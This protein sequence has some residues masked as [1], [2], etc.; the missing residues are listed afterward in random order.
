M[1]G[2]K[3]NF[4][5]DSS[6]INKG[7]NNVKKGVN[8]IKGS[9]HGAEGAMDAM[10]DAADGA[11]RALDSM[12]GACGAAS[13]GVSGLAGDLVYLVKNPIAAA[14]AALAA[15]AA[16]ASS[17]Y[18]NFTQNSDEFTAQLELQM[19]LLD[20]KNANMEKALTRQSKYFDKLKQ[21][22]KLQSLT[23]NQRKSAMS[24]IS[25]LTKSYGDLGISIDATTGKL[26]GLNQA[27][28]QFIKLQAE[29]RIKSLKGKLNLNENQII[30]AMVS[31]IPGEMNGNDVIDYIAGMGHRGNTAVWNDTDKVRKQGLKYVLPYTGN[32]LI[33][34]K[35]QIEQMNALVTQ[36]NAAN[37]DKS[38]DQVNKRL[39]ILSKIIKN[40]AI[41][42]DEDVLKAVGEVY[43]KYQ[44]RAELLE[45]INNLEEDLKFQLQEKDS[46]QQRKI[47]NDYQNKFDEIRKNIQTFNSK[48]TKY[49]ADLQAKKDQYVISQYDKQKQYDEYFAQYQ[50]KVN[51][52]SILQQQLDDQK[53]RYAAAKARKEKL[54]KFYNDNPDMLNGLAIQQILPYKNVVKQLEQSSRKLL[55]TQQKLNKVNQQQ[56][57]LDKKTQALKK[58]IAAENAQLHKEVFNNPLV[59]LKDKFFARYGSEK[60]IDTFATKLEQA[61]EKLGRS[62]SEQEVGQLKGLHELEKQLLGLQNITMGTFNDIQT[63]SLTA[64]GGWSQGVRQLQ[65]EDVNKSIANYSKKQVD[66]LNLINQALKGLGRI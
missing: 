9:A 29:N 53:Y 49:A 60:G 30:A 66:L 22:G 58:E 20:K 11:V 31:D 7:V 16:A 41:A 27:E 62:L 36:W 63:N 4:S 47:V 40:R 25:S 51:E 44:Q 57:E 43:K 52:Q 65:A 56:F 37:D 32:S 48:Q 10:G 24:I 6:Q 55:Q 13:T 21:L 50:S 42:N 35:A 8:D 45:Q 64:R 34:T 19:A 39:S 3:V 12:A 17:L 5:V 54:Q 1:A 46:Q 38:I 15:V 61:E 59:D 26:K 23:N 2:V 28:K 18:N 14:I 33:D